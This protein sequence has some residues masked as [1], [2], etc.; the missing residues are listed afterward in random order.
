MTQMNG[1][2]III[3]DFKLLNIKYET[4]NNQIRKLSTC[5]R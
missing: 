5:C 2:H 1:K 3:T 4:R